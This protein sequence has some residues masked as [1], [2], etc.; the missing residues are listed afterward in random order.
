MLLQGQLL[1][2][3]VELIGAQNAIEVGVFTGYSALSV[4]LVRPY[5]VDAIVYR[6]CCQLLFEPASGS[7]D[8]R[9]EHCGAVLQ[10]NDK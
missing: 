8:Q 10:L 3:L 2:L 7:I 4:A 9:F 5:A 6:L 1:A